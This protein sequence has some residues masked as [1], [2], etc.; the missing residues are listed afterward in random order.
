MNFIP[1]DPEYSARVRDSFARQGAMHLVGAQI[2]EIAPGTVKLQ[3]VPEAKHSQQHGFVHAGIVSTVLDSACGYAASTLM[4][5]DAGV[6][7]IEFK[8][9]LLAPAQGDRIELTGKVRKT[10]RTISVVEGEAIAFIGAKQT[11][12]ASMTATLMTIR[13][14][15]NIKA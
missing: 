14:R 4:D 15:D 8:V 12:V 5:A 2:V 7:T 13:G 9:N 3:F 10:G 1:T 11:V 6:M